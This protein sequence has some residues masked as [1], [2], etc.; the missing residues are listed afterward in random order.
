MSLA[1]PHSHST[2][3]QHQVDGVWVE[4][5][6]DDGELQTDACVPS[7]QAPRE[8]VTVTS[9]HL[10]LPCDTVGAGH[11]RQGLVFL[12]ILL[13][14]RNFHV[15]LWQMYHPV[16]YQS[17]YNPNTI[18]FK[19]C[20]DSNQTKIDSSPFVWK[21]TCIWEKGERTMPQKLR[22]W[23]QASDKLFPVSH[24]QWGHFP[25]FLDTISSFSMSDILK[26]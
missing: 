26:K 13:S 20:H 17:S 1:W 25:T 15:H 3:W 9:S 11:L 21:N 10:R 18:I 6:E 8:A 2:P 22:E 19:Y 24:L 4:G 14:L 23:L 7:P 5:A 12:T 16:L